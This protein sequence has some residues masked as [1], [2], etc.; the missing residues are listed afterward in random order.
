MEEGA[1][2]EALRDRLLRN[3]PA[4]EDIPS[5]MP[6]A[7]VKKKS[8]YAKQSLFANFFR[9]RFEPIDAAAFYRKL[10]EADAFADD[11]IPLEPQ[12]RHSD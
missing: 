5:L 4:P 12:S 1:M 7:D 6:K 2:R 11:H 8:P 10:A 3:Q 9:V